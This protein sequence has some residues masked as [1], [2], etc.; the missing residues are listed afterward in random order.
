MS[1][2]EDNNLRIILIEWLSIP[3]NATLPEGHTNLSFHPVIA[4]LRANGIS[5]LSLFL[6][7]SD[8]QLANFTGF[9]DQNAK[10]SN[11]RSPLLLSYI[12]QIRQCIAFYHHRSRIA[13]GPCNPIN[14]KDDFNDYVMMLY[15]GNATITPWYI[16]LPPSQMTAEQAELQQWTRQVKLNKNDFIDFKSSEYWQTTKESWATTAKAQGLGH[17]L[18]STFVPSNLELDQQQNFYVYSIM[19][20]KMKE[21]TARTIVTSYVSTRSA[22]E[23]WGA[24]VDQFDTD[25]SAE[26]KSQ[27]LSTFLTA[28]R[29]LSN[30]TWNGT[31]REYILKW[32]E[33]ARQYNEISSAAYSVIQLVQFLS[34]A[35][36]GISYLQAVSTTIGAA[37]RIAGLDV[38]IPYNEYIR[39]LLNAAEIH[40]AATKQ[41]QG[42]KPAVQGNNHG[43]VFA[44][45]VIQDGN[46]YS[47][48][49][50]DL[51]TPIETLLVNQSLIGNQQQQRR[52]QRFP[53][54][55]SQARNGNGLG[56]TKRVFLPKSLWSNLSIEAR[57]EWIKI[58]EE[59]KA[60]M[61]QYLQ[62]IRSDTSRTVSTHDLG[63]DTT[64]LTFEE[65]PDKATISVGVHDR[66][67]IDAS[68][69]K[70][71]GQAG[72]SKPVSSSPKSAGQDNMARSDWTSTDILSQLRTGKYSSYSST[73][74]NALMSQPSNR[75]TRD[76]SQ[77]GSVSFEARVHDIDFSKQKTVSDETTGC[78]LQDRARGPSQPKSEGLT[79]PMALLSS[80][81][82]WKKSLET[83]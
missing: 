82:L 24:L 34:A 50:H 56:K 74:V 55:S 1:I 9:A 65:E 69:H 60:K 32:Q 81:R 23:C 15:S 75:D 44:D 40:D 51:D 76:Y 18:D 42:A 6:S 79:T 70:V 39:A 45:D 30:G 53:S 54:S 57:T 7:L 2:Q 25:V 22:R 83:K 66:I 20:D 37:R 63:N 5:T 49:A 72:S 41:N 67:L 11:N 13:K 52:Q 29:S 26:I 3:V 62:Q 71:D 19:K 78:I 31:D 64:E 27:T 48:C 16:P 17:I 46:G 36:S 43:L 80:V 28:D 68:S 14:T 35:V 12:V 77:K 8:A 73:S 33:T 61:I 58:P 4:A 38:A 47:V 21:P 10:D 59:D